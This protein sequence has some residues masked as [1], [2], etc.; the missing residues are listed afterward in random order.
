[1]ITIEEYVGPHGCTPD[2]TL[3]RLD[4]AEHLLLQVNALLEDVT[5]RFALEPEV[6]PN[7]GS[8]VSG[9]TFGGFRPQ[10]CPQGAPNSSHKEGLGVDIYD[11]RNALDDVLND[12]LLAQYQLYREHPNATLGWCH[13]TT[14]APHSGNRTFLP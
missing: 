5:T 7:T 9:E 11:P 14:R 1:M 13:L 8:Q 6:N 10:S 3:A 4:N 12:T 2:W